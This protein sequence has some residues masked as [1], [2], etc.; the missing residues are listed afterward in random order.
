MYVYTGTAEDDG[1]AQ[2]AHP[3][4]GRPERAQELEFERKVD[5]EG[6]VVGSVDVEHCDV[7]YARQKAAPLVVER[8]AK[9]LKNRCHRCA[10]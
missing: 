6:A 3:G 7:S 10:Y 9:F 8:S 2:R 5:A 1:E 4:H